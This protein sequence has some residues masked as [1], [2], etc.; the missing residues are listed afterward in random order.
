MKKCLLAVM[1]V[2]FAQTLFAASYA[3]NAMVLWD[4][5]SHSGEIFFDLFGN[6]DELPTKWNSCAW[7]NGQMFGY[8]DNGTVYLKQ[9][10]RKTTPIG[11]DNVTFVLAYYGEL[12]SSDTI[13]TAAKLPLCV[14]DTA[15]HEGGIV[16]DNSSDFYLGFETPESKTT[17]GIPRYGWYHLSIAEDMN[18]IIMLDSGAGLYGEGVYVGIGAIPE[19]S[20]VVL[21]LIGCAGLLL[22]KNNRG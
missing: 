15:E 18:S 4:D 3:W 7:A 8:Q 19:P 13:E 1:S 5:G 10:D 6:I 16:I 21:L 17:D 14:W 9:Y 12:L 11:D 22:R 20:C 2:L